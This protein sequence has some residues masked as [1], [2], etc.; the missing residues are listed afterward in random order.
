MINL[1]KDPKEQSAAKEYEERIIRQ[2]K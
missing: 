2:K 1:P